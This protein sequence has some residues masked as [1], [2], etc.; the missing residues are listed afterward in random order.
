VTAVEWNN[1]KLTRTTVYEVT[2][3]S[4]F[5]ISKQRQF[6]I[7]K[8]VHGKNKR[9]YKWHLETIMQLN[10]TCRPT[11]HWLRLHIHPAFVLTESIAFTPN[12][13][14]HVSSIFC[15]CRLQ[16]FRVGRS[17]REQLFKV[18]TGSAHLQVF[19]LKP[20]LSIIQRGCHTA[21]DQQSVI[22]G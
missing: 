6:G 4:D 3:Y 11:R 21:D 15:H 20:A 7:M 13:V 14:Q 5:T 16:M 18:S 1:S 2:C 12:N 19:R 10:S 9:P 22:P 8:K 17:R